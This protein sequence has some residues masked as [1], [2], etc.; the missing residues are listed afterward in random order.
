MLAGVWAD[1]L[2]LTEVGTL[3]DFFELG[4]NSLLG[5]RLAGEVQDVFGVEVPARRFY[6]EPTVATLAQLLEEIAGQA[7]IPR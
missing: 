6:R 7:G 1:L 3:D 2:G 5:M 4:G